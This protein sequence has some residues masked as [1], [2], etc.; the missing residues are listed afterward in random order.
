M[1]AD[2]LYFQEVRREPFYT[3]EEIR[4]FAEAKDRTGGAVS[5][6]GR[7][8]RERMIRS[9]L[10]LVLHVAQDYQGLGI[11]SWEDLVAAGNVGLV[12]AADAY[13]T[14]YHTV[15]N[16][17]AEPYIRTEIRREIAHEHRRQR[18]RKPLP[19]TPE[20][21]P[22]VQRALRLSQKPLLRP[23]EITAYEEL[24]EKAQRLLDQLPPREAA[25]LTLC[26]G[27]R[28]T[29]PHSLTDIAQLVGKSRARISQ[30][31][32]RALTRLRALMAEDR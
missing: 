2:E 4:V 11:L 23:D 27:L 9:H 30:I 10:A 20:T 17:L 12:R 6:E 22:D 3:P 13:H 8:A 5:A 25:V 21:S 7:E 31:K 24:V 14:N 1:D 29:A 28:D 32:V 26:F 18:G 15:F 19:E 16:T